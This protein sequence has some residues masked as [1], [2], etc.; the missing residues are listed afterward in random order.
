ME[1]MA[2]LLLST[3][4]ASLA[5]AAGGMTIETM[6]S[7]DPIMDRIALC[8]VGIAMACIGITFA[9]GIWAME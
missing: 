5:V 4:M 8:G 1:L 3:A 2:K 7:T 6:R 9:I